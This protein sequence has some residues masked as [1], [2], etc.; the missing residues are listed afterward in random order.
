[1]FLHK[2]LDVVTLFH[3]PSLA[4]STRVLNILK[5]ANATASETAT[6]DQASDHSHHSTN[7]RGEF[8]LDVTEAAPTT[9]QLRNIFEYVSPGVKPSDIIKGARDQADA[10]KRLTE[11]GGENFVRPVV[12]DWTNG[13]VVV[14]DR[15]SEIMELVRQAELD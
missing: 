14:G 5:T 15:K 10:L 11:N 2:T 9:D 1:M 6:T 13:K 8:Q 3:K 4:A 7:Q 12:V